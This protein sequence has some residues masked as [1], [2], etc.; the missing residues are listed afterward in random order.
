MTNEVLLYALGANFFFSL[1]SQFFT[2]FSRKVG[3]TWMNWFKAAVAQV[4]FCAVLLINNG[5]HWVGFSDFFALFFSGVIGLGA[6]DIF[7]LMAFKEL[8]AGRTLMLFAFQ[9]LIMGIAGYYLFGQ[10]IDFYRFMAIVFFVLCLLIFSIESFKKKGD[11]G[12]KG[13]S[14]AL[15]GMLLD[16]AGV[17]ITRKM[18]DG[19]AELSPMLTNFYRTV[20]ALVLFQLIHFVKPVTFFKPFKGFV[21]SEKIGVLIGALCGTFI[22]LSLYLSAVQKANLASLSGVAITATIFSA[23]FECLWHKRLPSRYLIA[24]FISF[25]FGMRILLF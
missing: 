16:A 11:W 6:G 10:E 25:G 22:S 5:F 18:F 13:I 4:G 21:L 15:L 12:T 20:G 7:L 9:P 8:G 17:V 14:F 23:I 19:N 24:A 1:G 2:Y 3:S